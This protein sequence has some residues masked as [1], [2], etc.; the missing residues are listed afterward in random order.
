MFK[1]KNTLAAADG[2]NRYLRP[3]GGPWV[4]FRRIRLI[5]N[6][7]PIEDIDYYNRVH[8]MFDLLKPS[9]TR[10]NDQI[11]G[12]NNY[13]QEDAAAGAAAGA[14]RV[15]QLSFF[16]YDWVG[17]VVRPASFKW[18]MF[19]PLLGLFQQDKYIP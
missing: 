4:F 14:G 13:S 15:E 11:E 16:N 9:E 7:T 1:L 2:E 12:M 17:G 10:I 6:G 18:V 19:Q 3:L 8:Q 5:A